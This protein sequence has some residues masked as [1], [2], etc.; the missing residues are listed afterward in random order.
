MSE[1][2][3]E[4]H[5]FDLAKNRLKEFSEKTEAELEIDKVRTDGGFF[6][7]GD[8]K[9][10][11][12]E[13]NKR[14]ETIQGH[15]IAVNTTNNKVI[16]EFREVYNALDALDKDYITSIVANVKAIE[17]TSNDV[18]MQQGTLKQHNEKLANQQTKLD[19]H[20]TEIEKNV[21]NVSKIVTALKVFKEK[22]EG[23]K[24]LTD[25]DKIWNDCKTIQNEIQVVSNSITK[26]SK[27]TTE[28]I[29]MVNNKN[30]ALSEQ[31]NQDILT[32]H[33]KA[34]S[35]KEFF[36]DLSEKIEWTVDLLNKQIPVIQETSSFSEQL[37][38]IAHIIDVDFMW[39]DINEAKESF[40]TIENSL[41]NIDSDILKMQKHIDGI[42]SFVTI[43]NNNTHLQ[44]IDNMWNDLD[45]IKEDI[46]KINGIIE[47]NRENIQ[48][49]QNKLD[50]LATTSSEHKE[51]INTLFKKLA[52]A[53]EYAVNSRNFITDLESFRTKLATLNHLMEV[54]E[55][56]KQ[57]EDYQLRIKRVEQEGKS[58][59]DKLNELVQVSDRMHKSIDTNTHDINSLK[60][61]KDKL[62]CIS[63]LDD[64]DSM[65]KEVE[66]HTS[67]LIEGEK[68]NKELA[69]IIQKNKDEV[70]KNIE[71]AV[72]TTNAA[73]ES[74]TNKVKYAYWIAGCS[75]GLAIIE[76]ILLLMK[77]I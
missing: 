37:K 9:V 59:T 1:I 68:R 60:E 7:L 53:D 34:K 36:S 67:Q 45:I 44:D 5:S 10:T 42:D 50:T 35:F 19:A 76:L 61:Y 73:V 55:I 29:A 57:T 66:E 48:M 40:N 24:H 65:W 69:A 23:Y 30:K 52:D 74:L 64:V 18:R 31:V 32:L 63:H 4:R 20:Q 75:A 2:A 33:N 28:E 12:Y 77:V 43:L 49:H 54:D 22:L 51:S 13:L 56:W 6:G 8:H 70:N 21:A 47:E 14:L 58:H 62:S 41:Q 72:D 25:I 16:K 3:I 11:G 46:R 71:E 17:K 15:F 38:N 27:K 39:N 26:F